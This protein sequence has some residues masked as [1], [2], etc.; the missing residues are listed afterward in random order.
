MSFSH[1]PEPH[2]VFG[3]PFAIVLTAVVRTS[4]YVILKRRDRLRANAAGTKARWPSVSS[5]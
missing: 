3:Y 4:P 1:L 2:R 5:N